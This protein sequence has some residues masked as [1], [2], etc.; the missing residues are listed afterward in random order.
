MSS[1]IFENLSF[2]NNTYDLYLVGQESIDWFANI[3]NV[4]ALINYDVTLNL[5]NRFGGHL[6]VTNDIDY[7]LINIT[8]KEDLKVLEDNISLYYDEWVKPEKI[9]LKIYEIDK[10]GSINYFENYKVRIE[11]YNIKGQLV[12]Q[13]V[14]YIT[15]SEITPSQE[16]RIALEI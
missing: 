1:P 4:S 8:D 12:I 6:N 7:Y 13:E 14:F 16:I 3:S 5:T 10:N 9:R 2:H 15:P 11:F